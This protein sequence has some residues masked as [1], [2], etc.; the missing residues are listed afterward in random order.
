MSPLAKF[1][2]PCVCRALYLRGDPFETSDAVFGVKNSL[3]V[4]LELV[5]NATAK[6]Y[7]VEQGTKV[8]KRDFVLVTEVES[9]E[10]RRQK[11][12]E[13]LSASGMRYRLWNGMPVPDVD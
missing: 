12:E 4:D 2:T 9:D 13:V 3:L 6:R 11:T 1:L 5:N 8:L 10:L 7:G